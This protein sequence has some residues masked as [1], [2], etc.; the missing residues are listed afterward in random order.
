MNCV[1]VRRWRPE[2]C[3]GDVYSLLMTLHYLHWYV[4]KVPVQYFVTTK[5]DQPVL[6]VWLRVR[7]T[8]GRDFDGTILLF[9]RVLLSGVSFLVYSD[10]LLL[11]CDSV[12]S[13]DEKVAVDG[14][15]TLT[16]F[17][18]F[19]LYVSAREGIEDWCLFDSPFF[20]WRQ[21]TSVI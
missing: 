12:W 16:Y 17:L 9:R 7:P 13:T 14:G 3:I 2:P 6:L 5:V 4:L 8:G 21:Q 11:L 10:P 15:L 1:K 18:E 19:G 20:H